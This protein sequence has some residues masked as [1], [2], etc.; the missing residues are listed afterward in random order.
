ML[1]KSKWVWTWMAIG[2]GYDSGLVHGLMGGRYGFKDLILLFALLGLYISKIQH[3]K[4]WFSQARNFD[5]FDLCTS[6]V[7]PSCL[8]WRNYVSENVSPAIPWL[9]WSKELMKTIR[10]GLVGCLI[11]F[12]TEEKA[13]PAPIFPR[14]CLDNEQNLITKC[15]DQPLIFRTNLSC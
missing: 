3:Q 9:Q 10:G 7:H 12:G 2:F 13:N 15:E 6:L 1:R 8:K 14:V 4:E 11:V 5:A